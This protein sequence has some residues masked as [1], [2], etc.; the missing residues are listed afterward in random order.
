MKHNFTPSLIITLPLCALLAG[1]LAL[2]GEV[3]NHAWRAVYVIVGLVVLPEVVLWCGLFRRWCA[4]PHWKVAHHVM[5]VHIGLL[6][7]A[8]C[9]VMGIWFA[10]GFGYGAVLLPPL[11][12]YGLAMAYLRY[13]VRRHG[14]DCGQQKPSAGR[15]MPFGKLL[16]TYLP[17]FVKVDG[18]TLALTALFLWARHALRLSGAY[19]DAAVLF[20]IAAVLF[21]THRFWNVGRVVDAF[22]WRSYPVGCFRIAQLA[23]F[24]T[25]L[26]AVMDG[27]GLALVAQAVGLGSYLEGVW[28]W[29]GEKG[30]NNLK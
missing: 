28:I 22:G 5:I 27:Y 15:R 18:C 19:E 17:A 11:I 20:T 23:L 21:L 2:A 24:A 7:A 16:A 4:V 12:P 10:G 3:E 14:A 6:L 1:L 25:P 8:A 9:V 26:L 30:N 29:E 13:F